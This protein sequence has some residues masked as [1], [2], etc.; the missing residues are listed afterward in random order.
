MAGVDSA[1]L[2]AGLAERVDGEVRFDPGTLGAYARDASNY[3]QVPIGVVLPRT[4]D[5][6]AEAVAVCREAGAPVLS[7]GGGT[8]LEVL[9]YGGLRTW[10]GETS[11]EEFAAILAAGG[12]RAALY[13]RLREI[14]DAYLARPAASA[15]EGLHL[16]ELRAGLIGAP[17]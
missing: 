15:H 14:R 12:E 17:A 6:G 3:R 7:R 5:A 2:R 9:T 16:A 4:V 8:S 13:R 11:D 10:T 1:K